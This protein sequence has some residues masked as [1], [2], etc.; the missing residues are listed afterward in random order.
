M[1]VSIIIP[2][3]NAEKYLAQ[4]I[5][6]AMNQTL[7]DIE[8][9][10]I[11]DGSKDGSAQICKKY[12]ELDSRVTYYYKENEGLAAARQDGIERSSGEYIGFIDSDDWIEPDMYEKMYNA[13]VENNADVVLCN[14][15]EYDEKKRNMGIPGGVYNSQQIKDYILPRTLIDIDEKGQRTN[16]RW[17]NWIRIYKRSTIDENNLAFDR[18]FRRSQD[19]P[20]TF[21]VMLYSDS[22]V[23]LDE[24]LY[25]NRQDAG[26]LSRGYTKNMWKVISPL[27]EHIRHSAVM[28]EGFDYSQQA[29][30]TAFFLCVDCILNEFKPDAPSYF[31]RVK[32]VR[33]I[34]NDD[35]CAEALTG[36]DYKRLNRN[37]QTIFYKNMK[38]KSAL[39]LVVKFWYKYSKLRN[40][41]VYPLLNFLT[42]TTLYKKIRGIK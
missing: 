27:I 19:L 7:K 4:C 17:A 36:F 25:H 1:K 5:E 6:S 29:A 26:S 42:E 24:F 30:T 18:R 40:N 23:Y 37:Y 16:I 32:H 15:F 13:A 9:V 35:I 22:F 41:I 28:R 3:Y 11:D 10:L 31:E 33:E 8:I 38:S 20:F 21:D 2:I 14:C 12:V 39:I 34:I